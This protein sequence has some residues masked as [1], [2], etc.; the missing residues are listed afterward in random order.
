M[1]KKSYS[2][3]SIKVLHGL[4]GI[5]TRFDM[6]IGGI[7]TGVMHCVKEAIDNSVDEF[8][9]GYATTIQ[10]TIDT[11]KNTITVHD[12]G[13]GMPIDMHPTEKK[14]TLEV[15][16]T[17]IHAGGKFDKSSFKVSAG[18][19]GVG[20]KT[21]S[22]LCKN[23]IVESYTTKKFHGSETG[24]G[25]IEFSQGKITVPF[26]K[27]TNKNNVHGTIITFTPD[28]EIFKEYSKLN[29][30]L[31]KENLELRTYSNAG[32][33]AVLIVDG[34]KSVFQH[35]NGIKDYINDITTNIKSLTEP[36][37]YEFEDNGNSYE[38]LFKY[39]NT[40]TEVFHSFVN[41]L[42]IGGG[43]QETG[44][45]QS[46]TSIITKYV[47]DNKLLPKD[48]KELNPDDIRKG[49]VCIINI[50]HTNPSFKSQTKDELTNPEV[51]GL[52][53]KQSNQNLIEWIDK[54]PKVVKDIANRII[55]FAKSRLNTE[56]YVQKNIIKSS[57]SGI[58]YS[59]KFVDCVTTDPEKK[60]VYIVEG[61]SAANN[62]IYCRDP[63]YMAVFGLKGK[64]LNCYGLDIKTILKNPEMNELT[65]ILF[66]T[67]DFKKF[68][69]NNITT[70]NIIIASDS[71]TDGLHIRSLMINNLWKICP[72]IIKR[73]YVYIC[74]TPKYRA[75]IDKKN[76]FFQD[77]KELSDY[78][79]NM[80][81]NDIKIYSNEIKLKDIIDNMEEFKKDCKEIISK[82]SI[83][84]DFF[85]ELLIGNEEVLEEL[86]YNEKIKRYQGFYEGMWH[87]FNDSLLSSIDILIENWDIPRS[88]ECKINTATWSH[89]TVWNLIKFI[90]KNYKLT[91]FYLKG[92]GENNA[93]DDEFGL[94]MN[95]ETERLIQIKCSSKEELEKSLNN[96]LVK[97]VQNQEKNLY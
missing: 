8:I 37:F 88:F 38:V 77:D 36:Y 71:D 21:L 6:Y 40:D 64:P 26:K 32:L 79:Y 76:V 51:R 86:D 9:N 3:E 58:E 54:N 78:R 50:R 22:A 70:H 15:L 49:L 52:M 74:L 48:I 63:E 19:N 35:K 13:R 16:F 72:D 65:L 95:P 56:K 94:F 73:G 12:D 87:D 57:G 31:I 53:M 96:F 20:V 14:P 39:I 44:F 27:L 89:M 62:V 25:H 42:K 91:L 23:L 1:A 11:K 97:I 83:N 84:E 47:N 75:V 85:N 69:I 17:N 82:Y 66:E 28:E 93:S 18:K 61:D 67:N 30:E 2:A 34:K 7:E 81:K 60:R 55:K 10:V 90:N 92:L 33:K 45:K 5:R 29:P 41:G 24:I 4:E 43:T 68:D 59:K 46:L 80:V